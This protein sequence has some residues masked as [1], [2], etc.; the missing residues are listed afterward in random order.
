M[1]IYVYN[2]ETH[3][4]ER[5]PVTAHPVDYPYKP[6]HPTYNLDA[7]VKVRYNHK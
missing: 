3:M 1:A 4:K 2:V 5:I 6:P 7:P